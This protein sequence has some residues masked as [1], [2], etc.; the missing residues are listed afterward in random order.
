MTGITFTA[1]VSKITTTVDGGWR[2]SLD[3]LVDAD[4]K[5]AQ[6]GALRGTPLNVEVFPDGVKRAVGEVSHDQ[7]VSGETP[8]E[9]EDDLGE[10]D[11]MADIPDAEDIE[12]EEH[13]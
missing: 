1:H 8:T 4:V 5:A 13:A 12:G 7:I 2:V 3:L 9:R 6:L 11:Q 10:L